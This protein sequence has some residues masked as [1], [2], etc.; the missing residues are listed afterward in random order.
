MSVIVRFWCGCCVSWQPDGDPP[1]C[2]VHDE[3][4]VRHVQSPPPRFRA[5]DCD[6][7]GPY[8]KEKAHA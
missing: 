6:V 7:T 2:E 8:V 1:R 5:V 3:T 4:R